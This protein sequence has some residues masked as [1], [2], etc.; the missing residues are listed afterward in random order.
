MGKV[1]LKNAVDRKDGYFYYINGNGDL[2]CAERKRKSKT[3]KKTIK[4]TAKKHKVKTKTK[5]KEA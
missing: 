4:T 5:K 3:A 2:C 1:I